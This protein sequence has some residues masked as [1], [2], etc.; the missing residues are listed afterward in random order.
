[1]VV[2]RHSFST[3]GF[4]SALSEVTGELLHLLLILFFRMRLKQISMSFS[5]S[6]LRCDQLPKQVA[7]LNS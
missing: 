5:L 4:A 7:E 1:M 3:P 2:K 6:M